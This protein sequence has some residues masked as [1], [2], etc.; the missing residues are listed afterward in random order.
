LR[1][2][3]VGI[4]EKQQIAVIRVPE[5][6]AQSAGE[7][8]RPKDHNVQQQ[9]GFPQGTEQDQLLEEFRL[10]DKGERVASRGKRTQRLVPLLGR[11][12]ALENVRVLDRGSQ[13]RFALENRLLPF[14]QERWEA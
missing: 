7:P 2:L 12:V 8:P 11:L 5:R 4:P 1:P 13:Q 10:E 6:V 14:E 9:V 3:Q